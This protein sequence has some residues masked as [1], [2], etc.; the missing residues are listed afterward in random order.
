MLFIVFLTKTG[1]LTL[2]SNSLP[3]LNSYFTTIASLFNFFL[4]LLSSVCS[5][6]ETSLL[7]FLHLL[8][9]LIH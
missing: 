3:Q 1:I 2:Q 5:I 4:L 7:I 8:I 6:A 9:T